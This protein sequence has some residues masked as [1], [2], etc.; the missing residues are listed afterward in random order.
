MPF[1]SKAQMGQC[2]SEQIKKRG[3]TSWNC[4]KWLEETPNPTCLHHSSESTGRVKSC[5]TLRAGEKI[6]GP[7]QQGPRGGHFFIAKGVKIYIPKGQGNLEYA[8]KKWGSTF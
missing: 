7:V 2:F 4:E 8:K 6:I 3:K 1:K 5:R